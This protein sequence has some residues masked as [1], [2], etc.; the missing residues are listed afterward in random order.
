[1]PNMASRK[2]AYYWNAQENEPVRRALNGDDYVL[3]V[4]EETA[5]NGLEYQNLLSYRVIFVRLEYLAL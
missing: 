2:N 3:T 5:L 1:M 4:K